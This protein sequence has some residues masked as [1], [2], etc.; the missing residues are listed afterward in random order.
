MNNYL[1]YWSDIEICTD[2]C[3]YIRVAFV[4]SILAVLKA[5]L[6]NLKNVHAIWPEIPILRI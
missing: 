1:Q 2:C 5:I 3:S 6:R 4:K